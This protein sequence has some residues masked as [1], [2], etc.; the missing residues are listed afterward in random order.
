MFHQRPD[1]AAG[2]IHAPRPLHAKRPRRYGRGRCGTTGEE[3]QLPELTADL[4][5]ALAL[6]LPVSCARGTE[7]ISVFA[8][9][10]VEV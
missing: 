6:T 10:V 2:S 1:R 9:P 5:F 7:L 8:L 3:A 4:A